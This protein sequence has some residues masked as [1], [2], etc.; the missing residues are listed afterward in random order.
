M[1]SKF[2]LLVGS[3]RAAIKVAR[4][5]PKGH[6]ANSP[7]VV[8]RLSETGAQFHEAIARVFETQADGNLKV[9]FHEYIHDDTSGK[10]D[11]LLLVS[12]LRTEGLHS[13]GSR[14]RVIENYLHNTMLVYDPN[15][16]SMADAAKIS[17]LSSWLDPRGNL[18]DQHHFLEL[19]QHS[20]LISGHM[21]LH[22]EE[23]RQSLWK[24]WG[25][26][27]APVDGAAEYLGEN[28]AMYFVF[29]QAYSRMLLLAA[30]AGVI[31][32]LVQRRYGLESR[33][34]VGSSLLFTLFLSIW[35]T[36]FMSA[37]KRTEVEHAVKWGI[38]EREFILK[39]SVTETRIEY[40][41][42]PRTDKNTGLTLKYYPSWKATLRWCLSNI[43]TFAAIVVVAM[44]DY[45]LLSQKTRVDAWLASEEAGDL[46][47]LSATLYGLMPSIGK[48]IAIAVL[49]SIFDVLVDTLVK[50][51]NHRSQEAYSES[52]IFK[53]VLLNFS[54]NFL[55]LYYYVFVEVDLPKLRSSL[56][57]VLIISMVIGNTMELIVPWISYRFRLMH[58]LDRGKHTSHDSSTTDKLHIHIDTL[59]DAIDRV[60]Y[61]GTFNDF[62]ELWVQFGQVCLFCAAQPLASMLALFNN[63]LE[64]RLDAYKILFEHTHN[65]AN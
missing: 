38:F 20:G 33:A 12:L 61:D 59:D 4:H 58:L 40:H 9:S 56:T 46:S 22:D 25:Y 52:R 24:R 34:G 55:Y 37:W 39:S 62:L 53:L 3:L 48:A 8:L 28:V 35:S 51:E 41:G 54:T 2:S 36:M 42:E 10:G 44:V 16:Q 57:T 43:V 29:I 27:T 45:L 31:V 14:I 21:S 18:R 49:S 32:Y 47:F 19:L 13:S 26:F 64:M 15:T 60:N 63:G 7:D 65:G 1:S 11:C 6:K 50:F 23:E 5:R 30:A 17:R